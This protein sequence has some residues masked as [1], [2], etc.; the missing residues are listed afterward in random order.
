M[1]THN[2]NVT[3][4]KTK[5]KYHKIF[6]LDASE[7]WKREVYSGE[8]FIPAWPQS[9]IPTFQLYLYGIPT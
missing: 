5:H 2:I 9:K 1:N 6:V 8:S 7:S 3:L 4:D